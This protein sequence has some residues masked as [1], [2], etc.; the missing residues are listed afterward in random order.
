M[1][2]A[3]LV[4]IA[5]LTGCS[6]TGFDPYER[7]E[8]ISKEQGVSIG[9]LHQFLSISAETGAESKEIDRLYYKGWINKSERDY[10]RMLLK[11]KMDKSGVTGFFRRMQSNTLIVNSDRFY[12]VSECIKLSHN[13]YGCE[14]GKESYTGRGRKVSDLFLPSSYET[15]KAKA[16]TELAKDKYRCVEGGFGFTGN[17]FISQGLFLP[18]YPKF[19]Y[20]PDI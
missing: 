7:L 3:S 4:L 14:D 15:F 10:Q 19:I 20:S 5:I 17:G 8:K 12:K 1:R 11:E 2:I 13:K 9:E 6:S 18:I 16:C